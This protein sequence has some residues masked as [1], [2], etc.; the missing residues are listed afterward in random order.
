MNIA[1]IKIIT[2]RS[3]IKTVFLNISQNQRK[4]LYWSFFFIK[5]SYLTQPVNFVESLKTPILKNIFNWLLPWKGNFE[6][7][8]NQNQI[9]WTLLQCHFHP[10]ISP[11]IYNIMVSNAVT[12]SPDTRIIAETNL[13]GGAERGSPPS[14]PPPHLFFFFFAITCFFAITLKNYKL[15]LLKLNWSLTMQLWHT[16]TQILSKHI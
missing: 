8:S 5:A 10:N 7:A 11:I 13:D 2:Q 14:P 3:S 15:S 4:Y 16:F 1:D 12:H 9:L 6:E